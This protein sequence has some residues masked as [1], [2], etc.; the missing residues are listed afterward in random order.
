MIISKEESIFY[1]YKT[2]NLN[3]VKDSDIINVGNTYI[4]CILTHGHTYGSMCF[5]T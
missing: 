5:L 4:K 2:Q 3:L 1:G